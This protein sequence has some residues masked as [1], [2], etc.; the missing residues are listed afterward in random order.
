MFSDRIGRRPVYLF[1]AIF[2]GAFAFPFFRLIEASIPGLPVLS[3]VLA[4]AIDQL[5]SFVRENPDKNYTL[6]EWGFSNQLVL[7]LNG[8]IRYEDTAGSPG[9]GRQSGLLV[10]V[11]GFLANPSI[12][13]LFSTCASG[14]R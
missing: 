14:T 9:S 1:G 11:R 5:A 8:H 10:F 4:L 6:M 12:D 3:M 2:T 7:L 13:F